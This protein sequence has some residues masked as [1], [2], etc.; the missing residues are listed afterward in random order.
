[1][2]MKEGFAVEKLFDNDTAAGI[3]KG[4]TGQHVTHGIFGFFGVSWLR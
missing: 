2:T 1:M 3:T 4:I